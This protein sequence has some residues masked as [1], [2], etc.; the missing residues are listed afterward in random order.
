VAATAGTPPSPS[1]LPSPLPLPRP[2][3]RRRTRR[4]PWP[5]AAVLLALAA[6]VIWYVGGGS[7]DPP[8]AATGEQ[9]VAEKESP[10]VRPA[11]PRSAARREWIVLSWSPPR[12]GRPHLWLL[13]PSGAQRQRITHDPQ[14]FDI[15]PKFSPDGRQIAFI[16]GSEPGRPNA[17]WVCNT[18][19]ENCR[20][21]VA[22]EGKSERLF[23]PVWISKSRIYYVRDPVYNRA[24]DLEVW[25]VDLDRSEPE[26]V[27]RFAEV[28]GEGSGV[29]TDVSP[30]RRQLAVIAATTARPAA[31]DVWVC[32]LQGGSARKIW[33]DPKDDCQDGRALWSPDGRHLAWHHNF[34]PVEKPSERYYGVGLA[35][36]QADGTWTTR[37]QPDPKPQITPLAW[38]P[39]GEELLCARS[40][41]LRQ[42][43]SVVR[44]FL[45]NTEFVPKPVLFKLGASFW[46]PGQRDL[47]R[48]ADWAV[49][50]DDAAP[51]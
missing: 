7:D 34:P 35:T 13:R 45:M 17:L 51:K 4:W 29:V 40:D 33:S 2:K 14:Y 38:S 3:L 12:M 42:R 10:P 28:F 15:H 49:V 50:P 24:P 5:A 18:N 23:S 11:I 47:G 44:F 31:A 16:R 46:Q 48:L 41:E 19:G 32:D 25:A 21:I 8:H 26:R 30:D 39:H 27:F 37:I 1:P 36:F 22:G 6:G 9:T 20:Q 43:V